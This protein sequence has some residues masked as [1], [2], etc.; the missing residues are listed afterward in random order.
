MRGYRRVHLGDGRSF[1][2]HLII[3]LLLVSSL[4]VAL[5]IA[6]AASDPSPIGSPRFEQAT[7]TLTRYPYLQRQTTTS[8][9]IAWNTDVAGDSVVEYGTTPSYGS[10]VSDTALVT[11]HAVTLTGLLPDTTYYY[12]VLTN[13][14]PLT[15]GDSFHT[16]RD[17]SNPVFTFVAI[18]DSGCGCPDQYAVAEQIQLVNP[19]LLIHTGDVD[20]LSDYDVS[21]FQPYQDIIKSKPFYTS[22]GNHDDMTLYT[23]VFYLPDN[24]PAGTEL[25]Y[26]F[27]YGNAHFVALN[28]E[29][30]FTPGSPQ[31]NWLEDDLATTSRFWKFVYL[32]RPPYSTGNQGSDLNV[33]SNLSPLFEQYEVDLV[34]AGHDHD[35][36]R[37]TPI[38]D[39]YPD[40]RGV[41]Y[42]VTGG[43]GGTIFP[44]Q[45]PAV[46]TAYAEATHHLVQVEINDSRLVLRAIK[47]DGTVF[48]SLTIERGSVPTPTATATLG[49][50]STVTPSPTPTVPGVY[51]DENFEGY[52]AGQ[53]PVNWIDQNQSLDIVDAFKTIDQGGQ[54]VY[55]NQLVDSYYS[56]YDGPGALS[57]T[58]YEF[59]GRVLFDD[60]SSTVGFTFYS[61]YPGG[62]DKFYRLIRWSGEDQW[63]MAPRG[64]NISDGV[65]KLA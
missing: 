27:D 19:D 56:H 25:Y 65:F 21:F 38:K 52:S 43:G 28:T 55:G 16:S 22:F 63:R 36:E 3:L 32:H 37:T 45:A 59:T 61:Q 50:T 42:I 13:G 30:D 57:W 62:Q 48:D 54:M 49:G 29:Q 17:E 41:I 26:S 2:A 39:F 5:S 33:R 7:V 1:V 6:Q 14:V 35:Y 9:L 34:F 8:V 44:M 24:N 10:Q 18:G 4:V 64:T 23:N 47:P 40:R 11:Q 60:P 12:R 15:G 20:Y 46:W 31:Y 58:D 53:D 51:L